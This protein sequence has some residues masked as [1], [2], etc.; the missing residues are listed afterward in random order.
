MGDLS[1]GHSFDGLTDEKTHRTVSSIHEHSWAVGL[2]LPIPWVF[3]LLTKLPNSM[4]P[5]Y[6]LLQFCNEQVEKRKETSPAE[7]DLSS[8]LFTEKP[9]FADPMSEY[10]LVTGDARLL[11]VGGSHTTATALIYLFY[12]LASEKSLQEKLLEELDLEVNV[13]TIQN[14]PYLNAV[15]NETLRLHPP[16]P[17]MS[18]RDTPAE[19]IKVGDI[20]IP[21][22][23]TVFTS[24]H[25]IHR[26]EA[27]DQPLNFIPERWTTRPELI[28]NKKAFAPFLAGAF[29]CVG[30]PL[31]YNEMRTVVA[32]LVPSFEISLAE[33]EDGRRPQGSLD[34]F[35]VNYGALN[36]VFT[37][38]KS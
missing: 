35:P 38:R 24:L 6:K 22:E 16:V 19:G 8:H 32:K 21:G 20:F 4:N 17:S 26:S 28:R 34:V 15:I 3:H 2:L 9:F 10:N 18:S 7:P 12:H 11:V 13:Q 31:A 23:V 30:R 25:S 5:Q 33:G 14:L 27:F 37:P 36:L 29:G 1:F